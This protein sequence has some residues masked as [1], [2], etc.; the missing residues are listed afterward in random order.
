MTPEEKKQLQ[1]LMDWKRNMESSNTIPT[2]IDQSFRD[3]FNTIKVFVLPLTFGATSAQ[4]SSTTSV[5][6]RGAELG[7]IVIVT[8]I[9]AA[10]VGNLGGIYIGYVSAADTVSVRFINPDTVTTLNP[11]TNNFT[12]ALFK[13]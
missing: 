9:T 11:G 2:L 4:T 3:R 10:L 1:I 5:T 13:K 8:P 6:I 7:D 12:I